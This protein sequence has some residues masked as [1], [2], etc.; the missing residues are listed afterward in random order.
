MKGL[1]SVVFFCAQFLPYRFRTCL[2]IGYG[3]M[4]YNYPH[5][6][7][8]KVELGDVFCPRSHRKQDHV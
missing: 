4:N 5:L 6:A 3:S 8:E 7:G 1:S 2:K